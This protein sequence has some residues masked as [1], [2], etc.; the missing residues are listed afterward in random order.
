MSEATTVTNTLS[1]AAVPPAPPEAHQRADGEAT[2]SNLRKLPDI[3]YALVACKAP[4]SRI[5]AI[6]AGERGHYVTSFDAEGMELAS[7]RVLVD[8]LNVRL[9]VTDEQH[10]AMVAGSM[11]GFHVPGANPD[12]PSNRGGASLRVLDASMA[13]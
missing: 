1:I 13:R 9:G 7:A 8:R 3:C 2:E 12:H 11:F 4:G 10:A 6:K 5:V